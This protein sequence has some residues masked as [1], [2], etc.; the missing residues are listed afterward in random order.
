MGD[1]GRF[2]SLSQ[3]RRTINES[4]YP[5]LSQRH[6]KTKILEVL[7]TPQKVFSY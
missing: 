7:R 6:R 5:H 4:H 1:E 2:M 3:L